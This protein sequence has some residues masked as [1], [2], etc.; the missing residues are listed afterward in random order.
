MIVAIRKIFAKDCFQDLSLKMMQAGLPQL[1]VLPGV[2]T[3]RPVFELSPKD[4]E[5]SDSRLS[6]FSKRPEGETRKS[7]GI[8]PRV[9]KQHSFLKQNYFPA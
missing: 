2:E 4:T 8:F 5:L 1:T 3:G 6:T 9:E 7:R